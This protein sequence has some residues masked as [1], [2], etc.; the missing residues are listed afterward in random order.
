MGIKIHI[1]SIG[2]GMPAWIEA[3]FAE[4]AKRMP[5]D[6][7]IQLHEVSAIKRGE[8]ANCEHVKEQESLKLL[9]KVPKNTLKIALDPKGKKLSTELLAKELQIFYE[10][11]QDIALFI[12]GPEGLSQACLKQMHQS[13]SLSDLTFPHAL[14]RIIIAEQLYR[15]MTIIKK[16]PYHR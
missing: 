4:Y 14:V 15:A 5:R 7:E 8:N 3:G 2:K 12:G 10:E 6:F 16:L 1:L 11:H 9:E 13:W